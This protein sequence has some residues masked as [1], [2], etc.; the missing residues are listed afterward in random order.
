MVKAGRD[1]QLA[2]QRNFQNESID[3]G[4]RFSRKSMQSPLLNATENV[5]AL[6][7]GTVP[8]QKAPEFQRRRELA[9]VGIKALTF[10]TIRPSTKAFLWN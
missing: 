1:L 2:L 5:S 8:N 7:T 4:Y 10:I 3:S 9:A 6:G